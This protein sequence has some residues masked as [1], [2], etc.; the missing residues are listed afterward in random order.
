[1]PQFKISERA[2]IDLFD[3]GLYT[4]NKYGIKQRNNYLDNI[5]EKFQI[6]ANKPEQ[7]MQCF[8][9]RNGYYS[10]LVGKHK[11][12]YKKYNYGIRIIRILHQT[13]DYNKHL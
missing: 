4:Q 1:M 2:N 13:M 9:I 3:I 6:L 11:I 7:G 12:F 5:T 10:C 8:N